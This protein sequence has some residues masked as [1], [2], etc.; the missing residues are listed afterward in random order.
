MDLT[1]FEAAT[2]LGAAEDEVVLILGPRGTGD[3]GDVD[4]I[5]VGV[6]AGG[7]ACLRRDTVPAA[8]LRC[9]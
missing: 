8:S 3:P 5:G 6:R 7:L 2:Q 1:P 4:G 9:G